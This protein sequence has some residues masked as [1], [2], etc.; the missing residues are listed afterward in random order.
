MGAAYLH[1]GWAVFDTFVMVDWSAA[2]T[3]R[4]GKDSIW[5]AVLRGG[6]LSLH[7]P[8]TRD[9]AEDG[10]RTL[11]N[12]E[13]AAG[14]RVLAGFDCAFGY[15]A[16]LSARLGG[17]GWRTVWAALAERIEE[18]ERNA[19]NR[20]DVGGQ[21]NTLF[22]LPGPFWG[23]GL[24]RDI[25]GLPRRKPSGWGVG[26]PEN[27]RHCDRL[28]P[29]AQEV[30]KLSGAGSVGGQA[31]T[32]IAMLERLR[33]ATG[34]AVWPFEWPSAPGIVLAEVFPSLWPLGP[35]TGQV[36]D[37]RQVRDVAL[38][39][40]AWNRDGRLR[41]ALDAPLDQPRV[42]CHEEGWILGLGET[43]RLA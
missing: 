18:G 30:W 11:L 8:A 6:G 34:A 39:L 21:L 42:V 15:P 26:L 36:R 7:N 16:G 23:N 17:D 3:P 2:G 31:L 4:T 43:G 22:D 29:A 14:R 35:A 37:A 20:F 41:T 28:A 25:P 9:A 33:H 10:L 40:S 38:R 12:A 1:K 27:L 13:L 5:V 24:K 32:G 19:N